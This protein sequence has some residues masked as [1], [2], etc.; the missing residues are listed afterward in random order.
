MSSTETCVSRCTANRWVTSVIATKLKHLR[1]YTVVV[2]HRSDVDGTFRGYVLEQ[3]TGPSLFG[4]LYWVLLTGYGNSHNDLH[5]SVKNSVFMTGM[6]LHDQN[7]IKE[8]RATRLI[9][10]YLL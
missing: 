1:R 10:G 3:L 5:W 2:L 8:R 6:S 9:Y 4:D 7:L